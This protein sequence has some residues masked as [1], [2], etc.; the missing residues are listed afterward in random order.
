[1][2]AMSEVRETLEVGSG[3]ECPHSGAD[4]RAQVARET[5][6]VGARG[7]LVVE[8]GSD[9]VRVVAR[10]TDRVLVEARGP[11]GLARALLDVEQEG[12]DVYVRTS[13]PA[14]LPWL[15]ARWRRALALEVCVPSRYAVDVA[16][17]EGF[18][19]IEEVGGAVEVRSLSG[20]LVFR[21]VAGCIEART[22]SGPIAVERCSGEL[23]LRSVSGSIRIEG[24]RAAG[25]TTPRRP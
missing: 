25:A 2:L 18:V 10:E 23:E 14:G 4:S 15:R 5:F 11:G 1:M 17:R 6:R 13:A 24:E 8:A 20:G 16:T 19:A 12:D 3:W 21:D 22:V 7:R 9:S